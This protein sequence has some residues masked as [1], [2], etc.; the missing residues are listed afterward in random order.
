MMSCVEATPS[1]L[2][3]GH[4]PARA[5]ALRAA[6]EK[7]AMSVCEEADLPGTIA[8]IRRGRPDVCLLDAGLAGRGY[9]QVA[10]ILAAR[11]RT[12]VVVLDGSVGDDALLDAVE[13]GAAGHLPR[14]L[15]AA[16]LTA[17]LRDVMA[18]K[19]AFPRRV[20]AL[21]AGALQAR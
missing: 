16:R 8:A 17:A 4:A 7:D 12:R 14:D 3:A 13:V 5:R 18:G 6:L 2:L 10:A 15:D 11:P 21:L 19:V 9:A 1:V 20:E